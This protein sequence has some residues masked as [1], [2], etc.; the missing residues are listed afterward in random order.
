M[1]T[2]HVVRDPWSARQRI[3]GR[4]SL[5][6]WLLSGCV[7]ALRPFGSQVPATVPLARPPGASGKHGWRL[8][9][10]NQHRVGSYAQRDCPW[11]SRLQGKGY[12]R[13]NE[14]SKLD[15]KYDGDE[16]R[17]WATSFD[18]VA[19]QEVDDPLR[20]VLSGSGDLRQSY[21]HVDGRG[22]GVD[23]T[24]G[25]LVHPRLTVLGEAHAELRLAL[26]NGKHA[27]R[28][29]VALLL[30]GEEPLVL[31]SVHFHPPA[32]IGDYLAYI[33]PL[34]E[35]V[36]SLLSQS[37]TATVALIGDFNVSPAGFA[38][39]TAQDAF[40]NSCRTLC[41][42]GATAYRSNPCEIGDFGVFG[43]PGL[44]DLCQL[45][46]DRCRA[47]E[48]ASQVTSG[49]TCRVSGP[50]NFDDFERFS[51]M[52]VEKMTLP[53]VQRQLGTARTAIERAIKAGESDMQV[54]FRQSCLSESLS[55][56]SLEAVLRQS[57]EGVASAELNLTRPTVLRKGLSTSDH[58]AL[59]FE[60]VRICVK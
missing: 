17:L 21:S 12:C 44:L 33:H 27:V 6:P 4:R 18:A 25:V 23:C 9:C 26:K 47:H 56:A 15:V 8:G 38:E 54:A 29:H 19:L 2:K 58:K 37:P 13:R 10:W 14:L 57:L 1:L 41:C 22:V 35:A 46:V 48:P 28:D 60:T 30:E 40:W 32:S 34:K 43:G 51:D 53:F 36:V 24:N 16:L 39:L 7:A 49:W 5:R 55:Q 31:C 11:V 20:Q 3:Q 59:V 45:D 42:G 52:V 50:A